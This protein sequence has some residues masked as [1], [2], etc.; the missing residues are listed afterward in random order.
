M[1]EDPR[2]ERLRDA[3]V[4]SDKALVVAAVEAALREGLSASDII[5]KGLS[6]G[7]K[8]VGE[9]FARYELY[10][11]E[12][13][14]AAEAWE[15]AMALLEPRLLASGVAYRKV[16]RVVIGTVSGD[17]HS[18]GKNIVAAMLKMNGFEVFDLGVDVPASRFV[19]KAEEV[20]ADVIAL[21]AL[22]TTTM[23][24]QKALIEHLHVRQLRRKYIVL[25]GGACTNQEWADSI[26]ADGWGR[27]AGDAVALVLKAVS[28]S[29]RERQS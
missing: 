29:G 6:P 13:M 23:P 18:I 12:M 1:P 24:Q 4:A 22:M 27:T 2:L 7:M 3:V 17:I 8:E 14:M 26:G 21:S 9:R 15:Q 19:A 5:E 25:T 11:P 28:Q 16:G 10:L 20:G